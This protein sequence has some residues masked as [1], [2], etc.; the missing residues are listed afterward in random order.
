MF[1]EL[2][3]KDS[4]DGYAIQLRQMFNL[5]MPTVEV[6][7]ATGED[8]E[9]IEDLAEIEAFPIDD[10]EPEEVEYLEDNDVEL[11]RELEQDD[12]SQDISAPEQELF[13]KDEDVQIG[14]EWFNEIAAEEPLESDSSDMSEYF[15]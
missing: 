7:E 1:E 5:P 13:S 15:E 12:S 11:E 3:L 10:D 2:E 14:D 9:L 4:D 6:V 8:I